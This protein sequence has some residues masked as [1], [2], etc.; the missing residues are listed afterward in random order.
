MEQVVYGIIAWM[1]LVVVL[2]IGVVLWITHHEIKNSRREMALKLILHY[3]HKFHRMRMTFEKHNIF[4]VHL[5][6]TQGIKHHFSSHNRRFHESIPLLANEISQNCATNEYAFIK[7]DQLK[8]ELILVNKKIMEGFQQTVYA[9]RSFET[10]VMN[11]R[12]SLEDHWEAMTQEYNGV[13]DQIILCHE[14]LG[15][16]AYQEVI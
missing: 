3:N 10:K 7:D 11:E 16:K 2:M 8:E 1:S 4:K 6:D 15:N 5:S 14:L 13:L 9:Y 12:E